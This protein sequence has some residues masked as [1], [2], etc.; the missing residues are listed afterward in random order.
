MLGE[1]SLFELVLTAFLVPSLAYPV[2][3]EDHESSPSQ[4]ECSTDVYIPS[5]DVRNLVT[6]INSTSLKVPAE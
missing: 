5:P 6:Q 1:I 3:Q 4:T 2:A